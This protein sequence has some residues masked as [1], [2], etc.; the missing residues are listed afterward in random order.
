M[1]TPEVLKLSDAAFN[2]F[3]SQSSDLFYFYEITLD[4]HMNFRLLL[5]L[6]KDLHFYVV[7][8]KEPRKIL[9]IQDTFE[10]FHHLNPCFYIL[11]I[12]LLVLLLLFF[13]LLN[14][15]LFQSLKL[16]FII[17]TV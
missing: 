7:N 14:Q 3:G 5:V 13:G 6:L 15:L 1:K 10:V 2:E 4:N 17:F 9:N 8:Q 12:V 11:P 16:L